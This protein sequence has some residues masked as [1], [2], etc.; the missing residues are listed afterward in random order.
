MIINTS[1]LNSV[2]AVCLAIGCSGPPEDEV[3]ST[4]STDLLGLERAS[5]WSLTRGGELS[6]DEDSSEGLHALRLR[7]L[8]RTT[9]LRSRSFG[10]E[11]APTRVSVDVRLPEQQL[12]GT[13]R[14]DARLSCPSRGI[15]NEQLEAADL[16]PVATGRFETVTFQVPDLLASRLEQGCADLAVGFQLQAERDLSGIS[17][18]R[19]RLRSRVEIIREP[20]CGM[21]QPE[22]SAMEELPNGYLRRHSWRSGATVQAELGRFQRALESTPGVLGLAVDDANRRFIAITDPDMPSSLESVAQALERWEPTLSFAA[23]PSCRTGAE[24]KAALA[25]I[26]GGEFHHRA[27][28]V[29]LAYYLDVEEGQY[30]VYVDPHES[31]VG[32]ALR[33]TLGS[34]VNVRYEKVVG[35]D[36]VSDGEPHFG[37]ANLE[38]LNS[39]RKCTSGFVVNG[40]SGRGAV[41][42]GHCFNLGEDAFSGI[43]FYGVA[44]KFPADR[45]AWDMVYIAPDG[46]TFAPKI[47]TTP[48]CPSVRSVVSKTA[49]VLTTPRQLVCISGRN[50]LAKCSVEVIQLLATKSIDGKSRRNVWIGRRSGVN[51]AKEG[52]S[53]APVYI[54]LSLDRASIVGMHIAGLMAAPF[55]E[56]WFHS[57]NDVEAQL[58]VTV[59]F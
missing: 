32:E 2:F 8:G 15:L 59:A 29:E 12:A 49:P 36:R 45:N 11:L 14:L 39:G 53:G 30:V 3:Q 9:T 6:V 52:D 43:E 1:R 40:P 17:F 44:G 54:P 16:D 51:I 4:S 22:G 26:E 37:A 24:L 58:G 38:N 41:T 55:Q 35:H 33:R 42:A 20:R 34:L 13:G 5:D 21:E 28:A 10:V 23:Q 27:A 46:E 47:H 19:I 31:E 50:F 57:V 56:T 48:C 25:V 18:D 7:A